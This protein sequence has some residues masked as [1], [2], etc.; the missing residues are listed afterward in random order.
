M[1][2]DPPYSVARKGW[3]GEFGRSRDVI[4]FYRDRMVASHVMTSVDIPRE[5]FDTDGGDA[6]A[7]MPCYGTA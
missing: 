3:R 4:G 5:V 7:Q 2:E 6:L 1:E